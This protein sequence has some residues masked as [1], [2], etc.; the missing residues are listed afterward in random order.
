MQ[1][2]P[3]FILKYWYQYLFLVQLSLGEKIRMHFSLLQLRIVK[4]NVLVK[5]L[6]L[7]LIRF[8]IGWSL[9]ISI[10][11]EIVFSSRE[12]VCVNKL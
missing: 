4:E 6:F 12:H 9:Y 8:M 10:I 11:P 3:I 1:K 5:Q 2:N 7:D